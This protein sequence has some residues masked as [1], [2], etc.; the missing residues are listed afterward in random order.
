MVEYI[1]DFAVRCEMVLGSASVTQSLVR[2]LPRLCLP[3][4]LA[5]SPLCQQE[6]QGEETS[7]Y[8]Q[9]RLKYTDDTKQLL[10]ADKDA[11]MMEWERP[12]MRR[13]AAAVCHR[14]GHVLNVG[15]GLGIVDGFIQEH[16]VAEHTI[17]EVPAPSL[18]HSL[19]RSPALWLARSLARSLRPSLLL[20]RPG[21]S[22]G[23][24]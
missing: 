4:S 20:S 6:K 17:I 3:P 9:Q 12:L 24:P 11:V 14:G 8:L 10:D 19:A 21:S 1:L 16:G 7:P 2:I 23:A 5:L 15:F 22:T 13:H 18:P